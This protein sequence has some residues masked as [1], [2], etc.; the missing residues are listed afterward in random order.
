MALMRSCLTRPEADR[1]VRD[2]VLRSVTAGVA[3]AIGGADA[4]LRA[5]LM[6]ACLM[7]LG[8]ARYLLEIPAVAGAPRADIERLLEPALRALL[9]PPAQSAD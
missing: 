6:A 4:E 2:D 8:L 9:D 1:T 3:R 7:G 5:G